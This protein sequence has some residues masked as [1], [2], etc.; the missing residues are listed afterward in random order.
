MDGI[1]I[2]SMERG[3]RPSKKPQEKDILGRRGAAAAVVFFVSGISFV[4]IW[5][6]ISL[7]AY[8]PWWSWHI[9]LGA[10]LI[11]TFVAYCF[12]EPIVDLSAK[13]IGLAVR[14]MSSA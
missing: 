13:L 4:L 1:T 9:P 3:K 8:G 6:T 2:S 12:P 5:L 7:D 11:C 14:F 10:T